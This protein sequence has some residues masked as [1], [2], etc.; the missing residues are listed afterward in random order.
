MAGGE[1]ID[2]TAQLDRSVIDVAWSKDSAA[3]YFTLMGDGSV[4]LY[5]VDIATRQIEQLTSGAQ[6]ITSFDVD[7][8]GRVVFASSTMADPSALYLR[9]T[10]GHIV[11][12]YRPNAKFLAEH[13]A[14]PVEEIRHTSDRSAKTPRASNF[15][16]RRCIAN[17]S[18]AWA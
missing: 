7:A 9:E 17:R 3:L 2:L 18:G 4:N 1:V 8:Q 11:T 10:D 16:I 12:L 14:R 13:E 15:C 5:R 6:E